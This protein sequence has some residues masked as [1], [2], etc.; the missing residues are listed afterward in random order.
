M[1]SRIDKSDLVAA[2]TVAI[3][4]KTS[5]TIYGILKYP[6]KALTAEDHRMLYW[7]EMSCNSGLNYTENF[8]VQKL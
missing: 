2:E 4:H 3:S 7:I 6:E 1:S 8:L 5:F